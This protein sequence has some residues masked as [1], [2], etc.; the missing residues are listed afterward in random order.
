LTVGEQILPQRLLELR[1][2]PYYWTA[3]IVPLPREDWQMDMLSIAIFV[4][5]VIVAGAAVF[6]VVR[7]EK[8]I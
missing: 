4:L 2:Q 8:K 3:C 1:T 6:Y 5:A 7:P